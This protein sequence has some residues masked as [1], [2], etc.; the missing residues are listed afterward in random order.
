LTLGENLA[1][2]RDT[3]RELLD[4]DQK[5]IVLNLAGVQHIDSSGLGQLVGSYATVTNRGGGMK[6]LNLH[7][8]LQ[9]VIRATKL[10]TVFDTFT[11]EG[12]AVRS[13]RE[14]AASA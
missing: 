13:F 4:A 3:I 10:Y 5:N 14:K 9:D 1:T 12:A 8:R 2:F 6:L 11:T 7:D